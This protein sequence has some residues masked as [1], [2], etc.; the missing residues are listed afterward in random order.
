MGLHRDP[1]TYG[2][3]P[4]DTHV[5]RLIWHQ[6]CFLDIRTCEAQGPRPSIRR[7]DYDT[8]LPLNCNDSQFFRPAD[9]TTPVPEPQPQRCWTHMLFPLIRF[10][11]NEMMRILWVDRRK[12]ETRR[13]TLTTL[14][15]KIEAFRKSMLTKY[16]PL[17]NDAVSI[18]RYARL[19]MNLHLYRL[20]VMALTMYHAPTIHGTGLPPRLNRVLVTSAIMILE[21]GIQLETDPLFHLWAWYCGAYHQFHVAL[22]LASEVYVH[23]DHV[24]ADRVWPCLDYVFKTDRSLPPERKC[25][26]ILGEIVHKTTAYRRLRKARTPIQSARVNLDSNGSRKPAEHQKA[27]T[28][29]VNPQPYQQQ[30]PPS[31]AEPPQGSV[32]APPQPRISHQAPPQTQAPSPSAVYAGISDGQTLWSAP[33]LSYADTSEEASPSSAPGSGGAPATGPSPDGNIQVDWVSSLMATLATVCS[34]TFLYRMSSTAC[35]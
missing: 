1:Q 14:L 6:L 28:I 4:L 20:H 11:I 7:D 16:D 19:V 26:Q 31:F 2:L 29:P 18:Q 12:L 22:L 3:N 5:R 34:H 10:E 27:S 21:I 25:L 30:P 33:I 9:D 8:Q 24:D 15:S 13:I 23:P 32:N 17:L 35:S